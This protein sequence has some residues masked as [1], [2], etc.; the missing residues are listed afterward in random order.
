MYLGD[1][2]VVDLE[3]L[4]DGSGVYDLFDGDRAESVAGIVLGI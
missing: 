4:A 2:C 1:G 3:F